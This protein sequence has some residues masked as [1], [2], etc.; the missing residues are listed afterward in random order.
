MVKTITRGF[1]SWEIKILDVV[2]DKV[3]ATDTVYVKPDDKRIAI[4][5]IKATGNT[6]FKIET[7][8]HTDKREMSI[9]TFIEH[10]TPV[11]V[12]EKKEV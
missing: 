8:L 1:K 3:L 2:T 5:F 12:E 7:V 11:E 9:D 10:S 4:K 6:S